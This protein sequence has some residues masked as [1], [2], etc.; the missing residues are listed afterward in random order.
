DRPWRA[1]TGREN[2]QLGRT[3]TVVLQALRAEP[4]VTAPP[5]AVDHD[6]RSDIDPPDPRTDRRDLP[7]PLVPEG[8]R[9]LDTEALRW[10]VHDE[11][12]GMAYPGRGHPEQYLAGAGFGG[13]N[14]ADLRFR[15]DGH[16]LQSLHSVPVLSLSR[17]T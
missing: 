14:F 12:V 8:Q 3:G 16:M 6:I 5:R 7:G 9:E 4:A 15:T 1:E 13:G 17:T 11:I 10:V 2:T